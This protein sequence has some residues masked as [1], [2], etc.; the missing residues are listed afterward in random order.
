MSVEVTLKG[1]SSIY[2]VKNGVKY[3]VRSG[4]ANDFH[5]NEPTI[6]G[7]IANMEASHGEGVE[8][9]QFNRPGKWKIKK[10]FG[11]ISVELYGGAVRGKK[12]DIHAEERITYISKFI[13]Y[14]RTPNGEGILLCVGGEG[15]T[16]DE[17]VK[18]DPYGRTKGCNYE[19]AP[20]IYPV[21]E[22]N[23]ISPYSV[24]EE[25]PAVQD[26]DQLLEFMIRG[27][28]VKP[29][30]G[31]GG[32][33]GADDVSLKLE[34]PYWY[35]RWWG[36]AY[37]NKQERP[38]GVEDYELYNAEYWEWNYEE[39]EQPFTYDY[40]IDIRIRSEEDD[41]PFRLSEYTG[42]NT[43]EYWRW[44]S[45]YYGDI[46]VKPEVL[47]HSVSIEGIVV[48]LGTEYPTTLAWC[49]AYNDEGGGDAKWAVIYD[50]HYVDVSYEWYGDPP[51]TF[52]FPIYSYGHHEIRYCDYTGADHL[53]EYDRSM[54]GLAGVLKMYE[55]GDETVIVFNYYDYSE[56]WY[57]AGY[58]KDGEMTITDIGSLDDTEGNH[59]DHPNLQNMLGVLVL[60]GRS[61]EYWQ[62]Y[63]E[64][65]KI[66]KAEYDS[67]MGRK[68][69]E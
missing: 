24:Y 11:E 46:E 61:T 33:V 34:E 36:P 8:Q 1:A 37:Y 12:G 67:I 45:I 43:W 5:Q 32:L 13:P 58:V 57:K 50:I 53:L 49:W 51:G 20:Y 15:Y 59:Y 66:T 64:T 52:V 47:V 35:G 60:K 44:T 10:T 65:R 41:D 6:L 30:P 25:L 23:D 63:P 18:Y 22:D 69:G 62:T 2:I 56:Q 16:A 14:L 54:A 68:R 40:L 7:D 48:A 21:T 27:D 4:D 28:V 9:M 26:R 38:E 39:G 29:P 17:Y 42:D 3:T 55:H 31:L 19:Y